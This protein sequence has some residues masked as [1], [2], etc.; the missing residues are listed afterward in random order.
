[1]YS[2]GML[3]WEL[4]HETIPFD[5][6]LKLCEKYV[7]TEDSRPLIQSESSIVNRNVESIEDETQSQSFCSDD[8]AKIIRLCWQ[9]DPIKRPKFDYISLV[10]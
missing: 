8:L 4:W 6:D 2:F 7:V 1:M 3:M 5:G 9:S 10:L